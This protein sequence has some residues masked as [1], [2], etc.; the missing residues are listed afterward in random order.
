MSGNRRQRGFTLLEVMIA[1]AAG[2]LVMLPAVAMMLR[3]F[4]WYDDVQSKLALNR[5][6]RET[7]DIIGNGARLTSNGN[8]ATPNAYGIRGRRLAPSGALRSNYRLQ[9]SSNNLTV[10]PDSFGAMQVTCTAVAAP[11]PDCASAGQVKTVEGWVGEDIGVNA[12]TRSVASRTVEVMLTITDPYT[13][14]RSDYPT[15]ATE[16]YRTAF[17]L[18]RDETDP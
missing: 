3:V 10:T 7:I 5:H 1:S 6:A 12:T 8:D 15:A 4:T 11:L 2:M 18:N 17:T 14:Q 9:Y 13:A 16:R